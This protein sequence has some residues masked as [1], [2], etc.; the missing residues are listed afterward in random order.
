MRL[1]TAET[2]AI[3]ETVAELA[4]PG[5]AVYLFGSRLDD[6][7]RGGDVDLLVESQPTLTLL[8]RARLTVALEA[9]LNL[10]VD[11]IAIGPDRP[12]TPF[13]QITRA[14]AARLTLP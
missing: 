5:A 7:S 8:D 4:G 13:Q 14:R 12:P 3:V 9:R 6:A 1:T 10:P 11:L 2:R